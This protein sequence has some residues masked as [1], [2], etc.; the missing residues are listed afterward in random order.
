MSNQ[1]LHHVPSKSL[2][3]KNDLHQQGDNFPMVGPNQTPLLFGMAISSY[4][5]AR[6]TN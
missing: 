4:M 3:G 1:L 6:F 2:T 5:W